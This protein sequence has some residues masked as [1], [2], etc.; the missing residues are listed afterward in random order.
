MGRAITTIT[1]SAQVLL[2]G[3]RSAWAVATLY[4]IYIANLFAGGVVQGVPREPYLAVAEILSIVGALLQVILF[5]AIYE[6]SPLDRKTLSLI[7]FGLMLAVASLTSTVHFVQLT[8]GRQID[9]IATP[10]LARVFG[11][12]WPS[13]LYAIEL[14]AWHLFF[15]LSLLFAA[16]AFAGRGKEATVR[17]GLLITGLLCLVG[18]VGP[19]VGHLNWRMIGAFAYGI[20]FP[21]ICVVIA[22]VF[23]DAH[24]ASAK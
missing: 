13:L 4:V 2:L 12:E 21:I 7:A 24:K 14:A 15:G 19:A 22:L 11:W 3:E 9:V 8:V 6:C 17:V 18:L 1:G 23:R 5:G 16:S 10:E 20:L